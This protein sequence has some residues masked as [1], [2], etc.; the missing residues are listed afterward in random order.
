MVAILRLLTD[1][2]TKTRPTSLSTGFL[3]FKS[4]IGLLHRRQIDGGI[5]APTINFQ[6]KFKPVALVERWHTRAFDCRN[7][8]KRVW[9]AVVALDK[10]KALHRVEELDRSAGLFARQL[11]L[12][13]CSS[14]WGARSCIA[15][16]RRST[17]LNGHWFAIDLQVGRRNAPPAIDQRKAQRLTFGQTGK[18][19]LL[20]RA[21]VHEHVLTAV[22]TH[23]KAKAFLRIEEFYNAGAFANH[24]GRHAAATAACATTKAAATAAAA[25]A[26]TAATAK[27]IATAA[28]AKSVTAA[29]KTIAAAE[30]AVK[31]TTFEATITEAVTL[32]PATSATITAAPFIKTHA[33]FVFPVRPYTMQEP[34]PWTTNAGLPA[35]N[36]LR[37]DG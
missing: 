32:V 33:L 4:R 34:E 30:A 9:L 11:T 23:D 21:D 14:P 1:A 2:P 37:L 29:A 6:L 28:A 17:I 13:S 25:E 27:A 22:I 36:C 15:I 12:R 10:T 8:H 26:A 19:G 16:T 5:F 31:A 24:L 18:P 3:S 35:P 20:N 7:M